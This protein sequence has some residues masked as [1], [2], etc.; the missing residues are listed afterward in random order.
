MIND[1]AEKCRG[2]TRKHLSEALV[3]LDIEGEEECIRGTYICGNLAHAANHFIHYSTEISDHIRQV[4]L[5]AINENLTL[6]IP[7]DEIKQRLESIIKEVT[8]YKEPA[9]PEPLSVIRSQTTSS[10]K[11]GGCRCSQKA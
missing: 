4:R 9:P 5:D 2:C 1:T 7:K 3:W 11:K 8:E 10:P 6:A